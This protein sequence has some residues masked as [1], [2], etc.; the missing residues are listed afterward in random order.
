M[1]PYGLVDDARGAAA[2]VLNWGATTTT[3]KSYQN[4]RMQVH[5][6]QILQARAPFFMPNEGG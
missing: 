4:D 3:Y 1:S 2:C 5:F 6:S